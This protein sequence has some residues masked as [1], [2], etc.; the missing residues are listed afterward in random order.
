MVSSERHVQSGVKKIAQASKQQQV[1]SN[2]HPLDGQLGMRRRNGQ[3]DDETVKP[4]ESC[5]ID[6]SRRTRTRSPRSIK[7]GLPLK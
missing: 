3:K 7:S 2:H 1:Q 6:R 5:E 4:V